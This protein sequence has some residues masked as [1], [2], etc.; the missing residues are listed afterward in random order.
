VT[1]VAEMFDHVV[2]VDTHARTHTFCIVHCRTGAVVDT[3]IYPTTASGLS[4]AIAWIK[5]RCSGRVMAAVEGTSSYGASIA[6]ALV[7][8]EIEVCE[9]RPLSKAAHAHGGKSDQ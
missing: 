3:A 6:V 4:R 9:V 1:V 5:R 8:S 2:G 7:A